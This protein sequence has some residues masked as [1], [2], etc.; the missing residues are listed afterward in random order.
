MRHSKKPETYPCAPFVD[1][2]GFSVVN[3][4]VLKH[5]PNVVYKLPGVGVLA[6]VQLP[7]DAAHV[8]GLLDDLEVIRD[9][10]GLRIHWQTEGGRLWF[11]QKR[12]FQLTLAIFPSPCHSQYSTLLSPAFLD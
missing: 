6:L 11:L 7:L 4:C 8:H 12:D 9:L 3:P 2:R 1:S 10:E 5:E